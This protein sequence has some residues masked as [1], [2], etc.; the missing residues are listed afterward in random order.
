MKA[1]SLQLLSSLSRKKLMKRFEYLGEGAA[2]MVFALDD[3][4]VIKVSKNKFGL[5]QNYVEYYVY[6]R[7][8]ERFQKYLCPIIKW[9]P[10]IILAER[11]IPIDADQEYLNCLWVF[12]KSKLFYQDI[13]E[14]SKA[15]SLSKNDLRA[16]SSWGILHGEKVLIDYGCPNDRGY[17]F[18]RNHFSHEIIDKVPFNS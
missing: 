6:H 17:K 3:D 12:C 14:L 8:G 5:L 4:Q 11:A 10:E 9:L 13:L 18:Y 1:D 15:F 2:R 7:A 16:T